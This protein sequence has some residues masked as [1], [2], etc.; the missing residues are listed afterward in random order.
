MVQDAMLNIASL[1]LLG[2]LSNFAEP[3]QIA[4][5]ICH[6]TSSLHHIL[7]F[8]FRLFAHDVRAHAEAVFPFIRTIEGVFVTLNREVPAKVTEGHINLDRPS[9]VN[10]KAG[11]ACFGQRFATFNSDPF[12]EVG[13]TEKPRGLI[14]HLI[15]TDA[16]KRFVSVVLLVVTLNRL[17]RIA[18]RHRGA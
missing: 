12:L 17:R 7:H 6:A 5:D 8:L 9:L 2:S 18:N 3:A 1:I 13:L 15:A 4:V 16:W 14:T 11:L 10:L